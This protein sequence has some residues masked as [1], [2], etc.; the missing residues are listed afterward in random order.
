[1]KMQADNDDFK[2]YLDNI[3]SSG[4][5]LLN[6]INDILDLSKIESG[7]I[8]FDLLLASPA[9]MPKVIRLA[10]VLGPKG[11]LPNPKNGTVVPDPEATAKSMQGVISVI[12]RT[13]K[14]APLIHTIVGK[15]SLKDTELTKNIN[16]ILKVL[17]PNN[18]RKIVL[19]STMSPAIKLRI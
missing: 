19:K 13:E 7:K 14:S 5:H 4:M 17:P 1:M 6:I 15:L 12:L 16:T 18:L 11:L 10:K 9:Q 2:L 8:D 3:S